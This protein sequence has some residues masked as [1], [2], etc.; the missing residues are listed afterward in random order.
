MSTVSSAS[1]LAPPSTT[2]SSSGS[3]LTSAAQQTQS[4]FLNLLVT[5]LKDQNPLNPTDGTTFVTQLA[6]FSSLEALVNIQ[7]ILQNSSI[8]KPA[9]SAASGG[10]STNTGT[11]ATGTQDPSQT[12][13]TNSTQGA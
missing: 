8:A 12:T 10:T 2:S 4:E 9:S 3:S 6:Q 13:N 1:L 7:G 11:S 5:Q